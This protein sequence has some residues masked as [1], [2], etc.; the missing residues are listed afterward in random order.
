MAA[1]TATNSA[2][3]RS[4]YLNL[5]ITQLQHQNPLEP[6]DN[7]Q[8]ASQ[9]A[10]L[11]QLEQLEG[12]NNSFAKA[13]TSSRLNYA[14][15]LLGKEVGYYP[16]GQDVPVVGIVENVLNYSGNVQVRVN[17]KDVDV[18]LIEAVRYPLPQNS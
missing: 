18:D 11:S 16:E 2:D 12:M 6:M 15:S 14:T 4:Q 10:Q 17:G 13:L 7:N 8:M 5:L 3:I 9:L 1:I